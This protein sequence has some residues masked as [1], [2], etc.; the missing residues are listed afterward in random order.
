MGLDVVEIAA[1][2]LL[3]VLVTAL[4]RSNVALHRRIDLLERAQARRERRDAPQAAPVPSAALPVRDG[5]DPDELSDV[6]DIEGVSPD[7]LPVSVS[8]EDSANPHLLAFLSSTCTTC[9]G[10]WERFRA[11]ALQS[12]SPG[13]DVTVVPKDPAV[14]DVAR[15]RELAAGGDL[16]V[17]LS[18][19]AW[20]DYEVP[21]SP[22]FLL[23]DGSSI[24]TEGAARSWD[25]LIRM[26]GRDRATAGH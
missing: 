12:V 13:T 6:I 20:D 26:L 17:V 11:G 24:V 7:G 9:I 25:D 2:V 5:D 23:V 15:V 19:P 8:L 21:A 14:E 16:R 22:Y 10:F 1:L 3:T 4:V 18:S